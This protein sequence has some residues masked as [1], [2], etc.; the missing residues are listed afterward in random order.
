[1]K[2]IKKDE[3]MS[4]HLSLERK[5]DHEYLHVQ[6]LQIQIISCILSTGA[7]CF[8]C[9]SVGLV[10]TTGAG[11]Y[12]L[13]LFDNYGA[14]GLTFI[15][16]AEIMAVMYV[17]GHKKF[18]QDVEDMTGIRPGILSQKNLKLSVI[19]VF[20][21]LSEGL[22]N[23]TIGISIIKATSDSFC[24]FSGWY[25]QLT[26]RFVAPIL[27]AGILIV[28]VVFELTSSPMYTVWNRETVI[29]VFLLPHPA[30]NVSNFNRDVCSYRL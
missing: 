19:N 16:L 21:K 10:F 14:M 17:Y 11:E 7:A 23:L 2:G 28:S 30:F 9:F 1:M 15:G 5:F 25:W 29:R 3:R 12:W 8:F 6:C 27:L 20:L 24:L 18:T 26:W 22:D 4:T 13:T